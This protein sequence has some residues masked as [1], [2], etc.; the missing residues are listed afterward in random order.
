ML[1]VHCDDDF[2][3]VIRCAKMTKSLSG[4][5]QLV[6]AVADGCQLSGF[7][8][9]VQVCQIPV[10]SNANQ[11]DGLVCGLPNPPAKDHALE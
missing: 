7:K 3:L 5:A 8:T 4:I 2:P 11:A 1:S 10:L 6:D 9:L